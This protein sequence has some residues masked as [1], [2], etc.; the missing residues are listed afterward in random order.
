MNGSFAGYVPIQKKR[1]IGTIENKCGG[2]RKKEKQGESLARKES[3]KKNNIV[4]VS[5]RK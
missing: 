2:G 3:K 5:Q 4:A 1:K